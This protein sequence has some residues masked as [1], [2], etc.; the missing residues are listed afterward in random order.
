MNTIDIIIGIILIFGTVNGFLKG[1]F[2]E[3]TT[4]VGLVLGIYGAIHFSHFL[5]DFLKESVS[6]D[7]SM[8]QLVSFAGTFLIILIGMVLLGKA[9]TKIAETIALGFFNKLVGAIFGFV[10][11]ALILSIVLIVYD[12]INASLRFVEKAKV[13]K[14]VLY[15]PVKN[16]APA[17]FPNL[18]R[19]VKD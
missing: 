12:E 2:I 6:W 14:S 7:E 11:Y 8:L 3:V 5:G 16:F 4:L 9:M 15:E 1:L 10:K 17:I 18:V 13:K 19:V